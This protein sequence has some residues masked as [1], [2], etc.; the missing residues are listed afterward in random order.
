MS[1]NMNDRLWYALVPT[2]FFEDTDLKWLEIAK[3]HGMPSFGHQLKSFK[4]LVGSMVTRRQFAA[5]SSSARTS[6]T[7]VEFNDRGAL[8]RLTASYLNLVTSKLSEGQR[9]CK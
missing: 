6:G 4:P 2:I 7:P 1:G 8:C 5:S 3:K 9:A